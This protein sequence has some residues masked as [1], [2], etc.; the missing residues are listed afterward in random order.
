[1]LMDR[2]ELERQ[3]ELIALHLS[4]TQTLLAKQEDLVAHMDSYGVDTSTAR[5]ILEQQRDL[6]RQH[7]ADWERLKS[8]LEKLT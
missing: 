8:E 3:L 1:M 6:L 7:Q 4:E 2:K 5:Q